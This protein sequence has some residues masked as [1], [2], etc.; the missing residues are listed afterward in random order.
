MFIG[1]TADRAVFPFLDGE[2]P[3]KGLDEVLRRYTEITPHVELYGPTSFAPVIYKS[4]EIVRRTKQYHI[5]IMFSCYFQCVLT[6]IR[7]AD[8][9]GFGCIFH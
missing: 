4:L 1:K 3:C 5:L 9:Q 8:G 2:R 6:E 7:V